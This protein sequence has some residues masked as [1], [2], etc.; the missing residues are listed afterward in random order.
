VVRLLERHRPSDTRE[1]AHLERMLALAG[2]G[3]DPFDRDRLDPGHFT[4]SG[5]VMDG[6]RMLVVLHAKMQRWLQPGGHLEPGDAD[7]V[8]AAR[9]EV[10]EETGLVGLEL[11]GEGLFDVDVH[12]VGSGDTRHE[13]FDLRFLFAPGGGTAVAGDGVDAVRWA[14]W[15]DLVSLGADESM[16]RPAR[17]MLPGSS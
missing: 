9:R 17:R 16:L 6:D 10:A 2:S 11:L 5:F 3:G 1:A 14:T 7:P 4:A 12:V 15:H 8:S 13:H